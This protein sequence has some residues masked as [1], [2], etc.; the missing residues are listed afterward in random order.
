M[1]SLR[2][3]VHLQFTTIPEGLNTGNKMFNTSAD[4]WGEKD[5]QHSRFSEVCLPAHQWGKFDRGWGGVTLT[6]RTAAFCIYKRNPQ[7]PT[8]QTLDG[9]KGDI[10]SIELWSFVC[11]TC[12]SVCVECLTRRCCNAPWELCFS[13]YPGLVAW[14]WERSARTSPSA[15]IS[16]IRKLHPQVS[17]QRGTS[18]YASATKTSTALRACITVSIVPLCTL[19]TYSVIQMASGPNLPGCL[20]LR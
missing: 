9:R 18:Q 10:G 16:S 1:H 14:S 4:R 15:L 5:V 3:R 19:R 12:C 11:T 6:H 13:S 7:T 2:F 17:Q 20:N 8:L